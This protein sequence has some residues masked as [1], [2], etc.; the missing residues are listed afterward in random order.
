LEADCAAHTY[1][2]EESSRLLDRRSGSG[3][4]ARFPPAK[5][6][7]SYFPDPPIGTSASL[8]R[9]FAHIIQAIESTAAKFISHFPPRT[10]RTQKSRDQAQADADYKVKYAELVI[11]F[12]FL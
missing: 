3:F 9:F 12:H 4:P 11:G 1:L 10:R 2:S 5:Q 7:V 6:I 8:L